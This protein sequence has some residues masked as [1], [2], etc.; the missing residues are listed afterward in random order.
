M[1]FDNELVTYIATDLEG[2]TV[3][4]SAYTESEAREKAETELGAGNVVTFGRL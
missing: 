2:N 1:A 4:L 3:F